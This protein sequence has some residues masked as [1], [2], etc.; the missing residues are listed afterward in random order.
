M[1]LF[2]SWIRIH[3]LSCMVIIKFKQIIFGLLFFITF[4]IFYSV[5]LTIIFTAMYSVI[6]FLPTI[7]SCLTSGRP[8]WIFRDLAL[9]P[10]GDYSLDLSRQGSSQWELS[11]DLLKPGSSQWQISLD[12][13][14]LEYSQ[15]ETGQDL[16][17]PG[18]SQLESILELSRP[19]FSH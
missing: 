16:S 11:M 6:L 19:G 7:Q 8:A 12:L 1:L 18:N 17:R 4:L 3:A 14:R 5:S 15:W 13:L 9:Q 10:M 2:F